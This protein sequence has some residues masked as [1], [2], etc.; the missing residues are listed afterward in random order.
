[1]SLPPIGHLSDHYIQMA[2]AA[3]RRFS[4]P[5]RVDESFWRFVFQSSLERKKVTQRERSS[6][7][8]VEIKNEKTEKAENAKPKTD[9]GLLEEDDEFEEFPADGNKIDFPSF[10]SSIEY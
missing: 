10:I 6:T 9:L 7:M 1:M 4:F 8:S 3:S 2:D 5:K